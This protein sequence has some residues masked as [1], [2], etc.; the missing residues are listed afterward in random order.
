MTRRRLDATLLHPIR[1]LEN[2]TPPFLLPL[3]PLFQA[4]HPRLGTNGP[5]FESKG[6]PL[7]PRFEVVDLFRRMPAF[8]ELQLVRGQ[9]SND[10]PLVGEDLRLAHCIVAFGE[11]SKGDGV[12]EGDG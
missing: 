1:P 2:H 9:I 4:S 7:A 12:V 5:R 10:P 3:T 11:G 6:E 8:P